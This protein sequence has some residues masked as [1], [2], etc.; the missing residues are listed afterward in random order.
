MIEEFDV[1]DVVE[2]LDDTKLYFV[3][4][5]IHDSKRLFI[6][7]GDN[8]STEFEVSFDRVVN[9]WVHKK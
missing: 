3:T 4:G 5:V 1:T 8:L 7:D 9:Q 6:T 2:L